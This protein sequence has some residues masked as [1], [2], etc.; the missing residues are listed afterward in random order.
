MGCRRTCYRGNGLI[1]KA[2]YV[3]DSS[4]CIE[5]RNTFRIGKLPV[6][7]CPALLQSLRMRIHLP[8][9]LHPRSGNDDEIMHDPHLLLSDNRE[10]RMD[11]KKIE[12][13]VDRSAERILDREDGILCFAG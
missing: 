1:P 6:E 5:E 4:G 2:G 10:F 12:V 8:D 11:R 3:L 7:E 13:V 9:I